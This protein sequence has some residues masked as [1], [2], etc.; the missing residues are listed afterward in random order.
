MNK[1]IAV[2]QQGDKTLFLI[3]NHQATLRFDGRRNV[4]SAEYFNKSRKVLAS[5]ADT[6]PIMPNAPFD[7]PRAEAIV[8]KVVGCL[9]AGLDLPKLVHQPAK[10]TKR[11]SRRKPP[12]VAPIVTVRGFLEDLL[13]LVD[14]DWTILIPSGR[15]AALRNSKVVICDQHGET[16]CEFPYLVYEHIL[17]DH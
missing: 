3:G 16:V 13:E 12:K 15:P 6:H 17:K 1:A 11:S 14:G 9:H 10:V 8:R 4:W 7:Q 5:D 2:T